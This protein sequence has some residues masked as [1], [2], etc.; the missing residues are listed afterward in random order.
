MQSGDITAESL[1]PDTKLILDE[2]SRFKA[3]VDTPCI[4]N[5]IFNFNNELKYLNAV[6]EK[7][8]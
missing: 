1:S 8:I 6:K 3:F 5:Q 2:I 4:F 7:D